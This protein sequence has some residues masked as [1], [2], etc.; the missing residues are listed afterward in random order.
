MRTRTCATIGATLPRLLIFDQFE[1]FHAAQT[2]LGRAR[3][4]ASSRTRGPVENPRAKAFEAR[5]ELDESGAQQ[6][7]FTPGTIGADH[8]ARGLP[9]VRRKPEKGDAEHSQNAGWLHDGGRRCLRLMQPAGLSPK[10]WPWRSCVFVAAARAGKRR[11]E[12]P[13]EPDLAS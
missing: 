6:F 2:R 4:R 11:V 10:R 1:E 9:R 13:S 7:D 8:A 3:A 12:P 5:L